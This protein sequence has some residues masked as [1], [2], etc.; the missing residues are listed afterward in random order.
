VEKSIAPIK[1]IRKPAIDMDCWV[2][3]SF[4]PPKN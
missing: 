3:E 1:V 2:F 4:I